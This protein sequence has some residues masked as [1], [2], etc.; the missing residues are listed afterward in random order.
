MIDE[1]LLSPAVKSIP[2]SGIR[3]FFDIITEMD[4][5]ISLGVGEPDFVTPWHVREEGIYSLEKGRTHYT[6]NSGILELRHEISNYL[7]RRFNIKYDPEKQ[8]LVTVGA[9]KQLT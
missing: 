4:D 9:T 6:S 5:V 2:P 8:I 7:D 1:K 3:K